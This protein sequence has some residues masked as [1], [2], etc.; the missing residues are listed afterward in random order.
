LSV[1]GFPPAVLCFFFCPPRLAPCGTVWIFVIGS[2]PHY[3]QGF[4]AIL[5]FISWSPFLLRITERLSASDFLFHGDLLPCPRVPSILP[6]FLVDPALPTPPELGPLIIWSIGEWWHGPL[7]PSFFVF[8]GTPVSHTA[9]K[10]FTYLKFFL[11]FSL[12]FLPS[13]SFLFCPGSPQALKRAVSRWRRS[14]LLLMVGTWGV[15]FT[16]TPRSRCFG[17]APPS[18]IVRSRAILAQFLFHQSFPISA[19]GILTQSGATS[20]RTFMSPL[21]PRWL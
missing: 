18:P 14:P 11:M 3:R 21:G 9:W 20:F 6:P 7:P 16:V 19:C 5:L 2:C 15:F 13:P 8:F 4:P 17:P 1:G 10:S 12:D